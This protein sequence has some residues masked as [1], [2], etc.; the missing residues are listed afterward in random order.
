MKLDQQVWDRWIV[1]QREVGGRWRAIGQGARQGSGHGFP[2]G[3]AGGLPDG[4]WDTS[5]DRCR[6]R[7]CVCVCIWGWEGAGLEKM[8]KWRE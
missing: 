2:V 5:R 6:G 7:M 1:E 3:Q 4:E 8:M